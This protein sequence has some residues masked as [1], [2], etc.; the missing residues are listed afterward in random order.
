MGEMLRDEDLMLAYQQGDM[1]AMDELVRRYKNPVYSFVYRLRSN[2][3]DAQ[4]IAQEVF[5]RV[6]LYRASY[7]TCGKFSTWVFG[8][9][10]NLCVSMYRKNKRWVF[11]PRKADEPDELVEF[12]SPSPSPAAQAECGDLAHAVRTYI[13]K[14]PFLQKEALVL[15]EYQQLDYCEIAKVMHKPVGAI[16]TLIYRARQQLKNK[17]SAYIEEPVP[18]ATSQDAG[19]SHE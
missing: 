2:H 10:H 16:K 19:G 3:A 8:I 6:H 9:A 18:H 14:L 12:A 17:L 7:R 4:D 13:N 5:L 1:H 11:W 15:R